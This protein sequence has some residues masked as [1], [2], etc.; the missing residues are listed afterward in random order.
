MLCCKEKTIV[1]RGGGLPHFHFGY[2]GGRGD[3]G[4]KNDTYTQCFVSHCALSMCSKMSDL[5][6][7]NCTNAF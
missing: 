2:G 7:D 6:G 4:S 5:A 1:D 3:G